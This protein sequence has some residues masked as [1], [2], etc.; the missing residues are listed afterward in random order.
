[1]EIRFFVR[2]RG[3]RTPPPIIEEP[4]MKI[5]LG[6]YQKRVGEGKSE[7]FTKLLLRL[8]ILCR[9]LCLNLPRR[10]VIRLQG[11]VRPIPN[12]NLHSNRVSKRRTY[13]ES[14]SVASEEHI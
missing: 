14:L 3:A 11:I 6:L 10:A 9:G 2:M 13:I 4:V 7:K 1:M 12:V 5:P 8:I